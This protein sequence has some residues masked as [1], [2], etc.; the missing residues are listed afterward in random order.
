MRKGHDPS[1]IARD[2]FRRRMIS[3]VRYELIPS[4][5]RLI[6]TTMKEHSKAEGKHSR[7]GIADYRIRIP[8]WRLAIVRMMGQR[9]QH[10]IGQSVRPPPQEFSF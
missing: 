10:Q 3:F 2:F 4:A 8:E 6:E 7:L 1:E 9:G 5:Y